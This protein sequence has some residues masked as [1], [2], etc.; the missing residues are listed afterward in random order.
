MGS[1]VHTTGGG[2]NGGGKEVLRVLMSAPCH[3]DRQDDAA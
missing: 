3:K 1:R 2:S